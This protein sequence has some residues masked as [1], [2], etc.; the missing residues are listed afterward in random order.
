MSTE[1]AK[2]GGQRPACGE[3][4]AKLAQIG[5]PTGARSTGFE[6]TRRDV[7]SLLGFSL[8]AAGVAAGCRAPTQKAL[9]LPVAADQMV[10]GVA[11]FYATTCGG[12]GAACSLVVRQRDGRPIKIEGNEA[13]TLFG[14]GTCA[15][16]QATVLSL[17]DESRARGPLLQGHPATWAAVD[18]RIARALEAM[19]GDTRD[20]VL[21]S[22][23]LTSPATRAL[24]E[25]I[26]AK[27]PRFRHVAYDAVSASA[28]RAANAKSFGVAVVPH[29]RFR[30]ARVIVALD[31]DFLGT[32]LSPVE[33]AHQYARGRTQDGGR[34]FHVQ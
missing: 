1:G 30:E 3:D 24:V 17:Y 32:W 19:R 9:P 10:P 8:G 18:D 11:N 22:R 7:L 28:I 23:T 13:S 27:H 34:S 20:V 15:T 5:L 16:G 2:E 29:Y 33:F 25:V 12:C 26:R 4:P 31:A 14:G 6:A 21:L